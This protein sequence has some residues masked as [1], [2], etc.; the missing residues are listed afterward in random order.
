MSSLTFTAADQMIRLGSGVEQQLYASSVS[1]ISFNAG[2]VTISK[3]SPNHAPY[4]FPRV[5]VEFLDSDL[6]FT[7]AF[8]KNEHINLEWHSIGLPYLNSRGVVGKE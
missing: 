5:R 3:N 2:K 7:V 8:I 6:E 1:K 4:K